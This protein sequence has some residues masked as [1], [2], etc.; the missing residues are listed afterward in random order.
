MIEMWKIFSVYNHN[1]SMAFFGLL[2]E[3]IGCL[4]LF[5]PKLSY[6]LFYYFYSIESNYIFISVS[7]LENH[8][9]FEKK[10]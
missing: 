10:T 8:G 9:K 1:L 3:V 7:H 4:P 5:T 2:N 6:I